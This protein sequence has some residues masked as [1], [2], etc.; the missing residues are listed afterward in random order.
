MV[1]TIPNGNAT[2][3]F[4]STLQDYGHALLRT[5]LKMLQLKELAKMQG[6]YEIFTTVANLISK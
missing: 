5:I 1:Q 3:N 4:A 2:W 6:H